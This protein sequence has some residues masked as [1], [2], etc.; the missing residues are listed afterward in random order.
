MEEVIETMTLTKMMYDFQISKDMQIEIMRYFH[1]L[2]NKREKMCL[3]FGDDYFHL[4]DK[5]IYNIDMFNFYVY[6]FDNYDEEV[7]VKDYSNT[8]VQIKYKSDPDRLHMIQTSD[9]LEK[10]KTNGEI[11]NDDIPLNLIIGKPESKSTLRL[12]KLLIS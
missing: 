9:L 7:T 2:K 5:V 11:T 6:L 1:G 4:V 10:L 8:F 12:V 3:V